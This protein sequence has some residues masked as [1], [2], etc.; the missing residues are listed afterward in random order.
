MRRIFNRELL[1][2]FLCGLLAILVNYIVFWLALRLLGESRVLFVF[3]L[4]DK[5]GNP[6]VGKQHKLLNQK[7]SLFGFPEIYSQRFSVFINIK[8]YFISFK[9]Y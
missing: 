3:F 7:V 9:R 8:F 5:R 1:I 2:Y 4:A 6:L